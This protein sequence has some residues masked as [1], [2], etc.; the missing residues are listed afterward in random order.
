MAATDIH[1]VLGLQG[2]ERALDV[3]SYFGGWELDEY[4][5]YCPSTFTRI[6]YC[7]ENNVVQGIGCQTPSEWADLSPALSA[8]EA[9]PAA[10]PSRLV[11]LRT[12]T[13]SPNP[14]VS[15]PRPP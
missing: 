1:A 11:V 10:A 13:M 4:F 8:P 5:E 15:L 7:D 12:G 6:D 9:C 3:E 2:W 14:P